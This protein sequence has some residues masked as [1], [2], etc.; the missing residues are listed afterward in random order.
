MK[1]VWINYYLNGEMV[2]E[3]CFE[4]TGTKKWSSLEIA[5]QKAIRFA[6]DNEFDMWDYKPY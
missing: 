4:V 1:R 5:F 3:E 6:E 2:H